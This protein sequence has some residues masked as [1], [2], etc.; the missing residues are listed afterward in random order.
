MWWIVSTTSWL[1]IPRKETRTQYTESWIGPGAALDG[2][3]KS[4]H[5]VRNEWL[6][7]LRYP[8]RHSVIVLKLM[9]I[10]RYK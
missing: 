3:G 10:K 5:P 4:N 8:S 1:F 9:I 6:Y 7:R 2:Y